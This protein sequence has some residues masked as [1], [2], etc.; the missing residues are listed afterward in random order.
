MIVTITGLIQGSCSP[1]I[2]HGS[3]ISDCVCSENYLTQF[4]ISSVLP[5][6]APSTARSALRIAIIFFYISIK[7]TTEFIEPAFEFN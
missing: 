6:A 3:H 5:C 4:I 1:A 2:T 7:L